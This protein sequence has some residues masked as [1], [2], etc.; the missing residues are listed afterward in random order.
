LGRSSHFASADC[1]DWFISNYNFAADKEAHKSDRADEHSQV[2]TDL[3]SYSFNRSIT[4]LNWASTT[5]AVCPD[6]RS[7]KVSPTQRM[8]LSPASR[9]ARVFSATNSEVS[10]KSVRRSECPMLNYSE[11]KGI[12]RNRI[13]TENYKRN[14]GI[15]ELS[16]TGRVNLDLNTLCRT[17]SKHEPTLSRRY[18]RLNSCYNNSAPKPWCPAWGSPTAG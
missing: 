6:S 16:R 2:E 1:P 11:I 10:W 9:A 15:D 12:R 7:C 4:V 17:V 3:Q 13:R 8:T 18:M 5:A 14:S